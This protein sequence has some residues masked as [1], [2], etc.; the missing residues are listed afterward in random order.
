MSVR[1]S[2]KAKWS[3]VVKHGV[4]LGGVVLGTMNCLPGQDGALDFAAFEM[5][6]FD[7][8]DELEAHL[9]DRASQKAQLQSVAAISG[10]AWSPAGFSDNTPGDT[11]A[12]NNQEQG[13]DE[14]DVFKV[15]DRYA[16]A[17]HGGK[18]VIAGAEGEG[19]GER[20]QIANGRVLS[21]TPIQGQPFEMHLAGDKVMILA[22]TER[23]ELEERFQSAA[24]A[25]DKDVPVFKAALYDVSDRTSPKLLREVLLE[26]QHLA[27]RRID[28]KV[29]IVTQAMLG[30]PAL[31][32]A[33]AG[34]ERWLTARRNS[35][36]A[37]RIDSWLPSYYDVKY[38]GGQASTDV[39]RCSCRDTWQSPSADG[40]DLLAVYTLDLADAEKSVT[41]SAVI[42]E[43]GH[44]YASTKQLVV[45]FPDQGKKAPQRVQTPDDFEDDPFADDPFGDNEDA[46]AEDFAD[47]G[48]ITYLHQFNIRTDGKIAY[49]GSGQ[50]DGWILNQFSI[51]EHEGILRVATMNGEIGAGDAR[52]NVF[53]LKST[54]KASQSYQSDE[55]ASGSFLKVIGEL[56]NIAPNED[57]YSTR[58]RGDI[59]YL[60]T[61]RETDPLW[62]IDLSDPTE[63]RVLGELMVPG[64]S[65]YIHPISDSRILAVGRGGWQ[66]DNGV[67]LSLFDVG[68]LSAPSVVDEHV[69]GDQST[70]SEALEEHRAFNY[71]SKYGI[72]ALPIQQGGNAN[73]QLWRVRTNASFVLEGVLDHG[74]MA[75]RG[76][77]VVRRSLLSGRYLWALSEAGLSITDMESLDTVARIDLEDGDIED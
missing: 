75:Q 72:L 38:Q 30:G 10:S 20:F 62:T 28:N 70:T 63:P 3:K 42:G 17:L 47:D 34:G 67:K 69:I 73:L 45:G 31:D 24:V 26:G 29:H 58:F 25:R 43:G 71:M 48:K 65:T 56:R 37:A 23:T 74:S 35:I 18:L 13:V 6:S 57:L 64:Y 16:Y 5:R 54:R 1:G 14:A 15:D 51:S 60:I 21:Q 2:Q 40:D 52:S 55:G 59:A 39:E 12:T 36:R 19:S 77:S 33:P 44:V 4:V 61:F 76:N 49:G 46:F 66:D 11:S 22:R 32:E 68:R 27:S 53:T 41:T 50:V 7:D 8:C 9:K